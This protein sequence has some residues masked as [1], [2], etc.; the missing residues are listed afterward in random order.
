MK[1]VSRERGIVSIADCP[2]MSVETIQ[3]GHRNQSIS[4]TVS[5]ILRQNARTVSDTN[6]VTRGARKKYVKKVSINNRKIEMLKIPG[7]I[8]V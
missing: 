6:N 3:R 1:R 2:I 4:N 8:F 7:A 5:N